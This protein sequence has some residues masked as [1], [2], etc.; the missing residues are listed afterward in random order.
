M[1][2]ARLELATSRVA[3]FGIPRNLV[4]VPL[5]AP[6]SQAFACGCYPDLLNSLF[7]YAVENPQWFPGGD[8]RGYRAVQAA[9]A[10]LTAVHIDGMVV[11][12]LDGFVRLIDAIGGL[13]IVTP[14]AVYDPRYPHENGTQHEEIF[15]PAGSHHLD[16]HM[17]LAFARSRYQ[18]S[19]YDRMF[20]QQLVLTS[21]RRQ[22]NPCDLVFRIPELLDIA[23]DSLWTNLPIEALPDL[24]AA[25]AGVKVDRIVRHQ[26]WPPQIHELLD[27]ASVALVREIVANPFVVEGA[28]PRPS[29]SASPTPEPAPA[30]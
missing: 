23:R 28:S 26:L 14:Y 9:I 22:V 2:L 8:D 20:R 11:V 30:C 3:L 21:L 27:P 10:E 16:G 6:A 25:A 15:I 24:L 4:N 5:P 17:A 7:R 1:I 13:D 18:D 12:T 29:A 19:D